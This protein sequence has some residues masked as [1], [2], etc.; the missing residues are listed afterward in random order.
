MP[1]IAPTPEELIKEFLAASF[2][3]TILTSVTLGTV[4]QTS[5][6]KWRDSRVVSRATFWAHEQEVRVRRSVKLGG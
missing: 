6:S 1:T 5:V 4:S 2:L 3:F